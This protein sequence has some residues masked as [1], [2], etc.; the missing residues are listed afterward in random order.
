MLISMNINVFKKKCIES[1]INYFTVRKKNFSK[2][3]PLI[4]HYKILIY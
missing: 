3:N 1:L 2:K 4:M